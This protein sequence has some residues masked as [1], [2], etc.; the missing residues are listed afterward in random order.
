[1]TRLAL[2]ALAAVAFTLFDTACHA[3]EPSLQ[4]E[5]WVEPVPVQRPP[6]NYPSGAQQIS[7]EG[8][9]ALSYIVSKDGAVTDAMIEDSTGSESFERAALDAVRKWRY[10]PA[11][12]NGEAIEHPMTRTVIRFMIKGETGASHDFSVRY[13]EINRVLAAGD[14]PKAQELLADL[15]D[16]AR[17]NLYEDAWFWWL[18]YTVLA[19]GKTADREEMLKA[20]SAAVGYENDYLL[21]DM[22]LA[23]SSRMFLL[24]LQDNDL[25]GALDAFERL[26]TSKA[27]K[28]SKDYERVVTALGANVEEIRKYI[29]SDATLLNTGRVSPHEYWV[30]TLVRR[31]FSLGDIDGNVQ[32]LEVRCKRQQTRYQPVTDQHTWTVPASWEK[33]GVYVHGAPGATFK[34]YEYPDRG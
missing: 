10:K 20:L 17:R 30:H 34:F 28:E 14:V 22:F 29:T 24:R 4:A 26:T 13:R 31:S 9:V 18:K 11:T 16:K 15:S 7:L 3:Q 8:W 19:A 23:A 27:A 25:G 1:L 5:T 33:C 21:P 2:L 32:A 12:R 6:P